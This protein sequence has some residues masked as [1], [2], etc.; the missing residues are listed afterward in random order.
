MK[1]QWGQLALRI[2]GASFVAGPLFGLLSYLLMIVAT[3][4][5]GEA[6]NF[7][8][9]ATLPLFLGLAAFVGAIYA[10]PAYLVGGFGMAALG[11]RYRWARSK[12]AWL[13]MGGV[14]GI[15]VGIMFGTYDSLPIQVANMVAA[16]AAAAICAWVCHYPPVWSAAAEPA[17]AEPE[18]A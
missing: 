1:A 16:I 3:L 9:L 11:G 7:D 10:L 14:I 15:P 17:T 12:F 2:V 5:S 13:V 6:F 4:A 18:T 8:D